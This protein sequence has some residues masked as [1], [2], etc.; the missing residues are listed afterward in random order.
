MLAVRV[1]NILRLD[2]AIFCRFFK[3]PNKLLYASVLYLNRD[4]IGGC[5]IGVNFGLTRFQDVLVGYR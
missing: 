3:Q 4:G 2:S 1:E 5:Q